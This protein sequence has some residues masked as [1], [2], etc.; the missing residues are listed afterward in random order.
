MASPMQPRRISLERTSTQIVGNETLVYDELRHRAWCLNNSSACIWR[1]CSGDK[2]VE[3][4]A[5]AATAELDA[6]VTEEI[7]L[8][9]LAELQEKDLLE[10]ESAPL[11]PEGITR[12]EMM[13]RAALT[14]AA[15]LPVIA[16]VMAPP[17][18]AQS[19]SLNGISRRAGSVSDS[20]K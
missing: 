15:L 13:G 7:V 11:L 20:L 14:A 6:P 16:S 5:V 1:L 3:Q 18:Q 9:T 17:A 12:R 4:I 2:T 8:V 19:G 10:R